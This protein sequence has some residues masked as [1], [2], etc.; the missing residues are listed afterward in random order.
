MVSP[1]ARELVLLLVSPR[2]ARDGS[3]GKVH[4]TRRAR[5]FMFPSGAWRRACCCGLLGN[6]FARRG[7]MSLSPL[8]IA[9]SRGP[10]DAAVVRNALPS[11][12]PLLILPFSGD[13][14]R[15]SMRQ[16]SHCSRSSI[17]KAMS[18]ASSTV[19]GSAVSPSA[20]PLHGKLAI[21]T[22]SSRGMPCMCVCVRGPHYSA[23]ERAGIGAAA[24]ENL[25]A[26][27]CELVLHY[28]STTSAGDARSLAAALEAK[29]AVRCAVIQADL[30]RDGGPE[31]FIA[32][33]KQH[34]SAPDGTFRIDILG[35]LSHNTGPL[36][37]VATHAAPVNNAGMVHNATLGNI[38]SD[39][40][41]TVFRINTLAPLLTM[42]ATMPY[43]PH[44]R[45][46]R[47]VNVSSVSSTNG[48]ADQSIYG[49]SKAA[50]E[51]CTKS[52][53]RQLAERCTVNA[54]NPGPVKTEMWGGLTE[55]FVEDHKPWFK[56][57][58]LMAVRADDTETDKAEAKHLGGVVASP[59]KIAGII[60]MLCSS[61]SAWCTGQTVSANGG[62]RMSE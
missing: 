13:A 30:S 39:D 26:K 49:G 56:L 18:S 22:G 20:R 37:H 48:N 8:R 11:A 3:N 51:A 33:A 46:G 15:Y 28:N 43:L 9:I 12:Q 34:M 6:A 38:T 35:E 44:D 4:V 53:A 47:V 59:D 10:H 16:R 60:G 7:A 41:Y 2:R 58:P 17:S 24:A 50:L 21:I 61:E 42:Q 14:V 25:A 40:F 23:D 5:R 57:A 45:S 1:T 36:A 55:K 27:G 19:R 32:A 29:H 52:W 54:I 31:H 62:M